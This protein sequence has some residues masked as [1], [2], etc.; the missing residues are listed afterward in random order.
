M[1]RINTPDSHHVGPSPLPG[2]HS[3][4]SFTNV[5]YVATVR[6]AMHVIQAKITT[7]TPCNNAFRA[8]PGGRTLTQI[9]AD[10]SVWINFDPSRNAGDYAATRGN[11]VTIT[12]FTLSKGHWTTAATLVHELGHVGGAP[13]GTSPLAEQI[14]LPCLLGELRQPGLVGELIRANRARINA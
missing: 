10:P 12:A 5:G 13:G 6:A 1:P 2:G 3:Y 14:L 7:S 9:W 4:L 11:D 8:L